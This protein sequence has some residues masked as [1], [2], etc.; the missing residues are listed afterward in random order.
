VENP[1]PTQI[2]IK[3]H[4]RRTFRS[5]RWPIGNMNHRHAPPTAAT[6]QVVA[7]RI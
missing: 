1:V 3:R 5:A 7:L 6:R 4:T 2:V